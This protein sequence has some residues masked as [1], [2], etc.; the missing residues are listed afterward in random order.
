MTNGVTTDEREEIEEALFATHMAADQY[1]LRGKAT[2]ETMLRISVNEALSLLE[3]YKD[4]LKDDP[5]VENYKLHLFV[6]LQMRQLL[7]MRKEKE[8]VEQS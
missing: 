4:K 5:M 3:K 8:N 7:E 6:P 1:L 2:H